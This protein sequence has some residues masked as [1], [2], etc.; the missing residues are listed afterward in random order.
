[1]LL[2]FWLF[3]CCSSTNWLVAYSLQEREKRAKKKEKRK[4]TASTDAVVNT[5][6][7]PAPS[8]ETLSRTSEESDQVE[9]PVEVTKRSLKPSQFT[10][11]TKVKPLPMAIRNRGK[12]RLQPWM[13][14]V[15]A[16]LAVV[17]LFLVGNNSSL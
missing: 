9:K 17:A 5:E 15:I 11:Q 1:M 13:W 12:R 7:E 14:V 10:K 16:V 4:T 6:Q 3:I 2:G 8:S